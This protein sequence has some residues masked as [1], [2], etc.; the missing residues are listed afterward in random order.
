LLRVAPEIRQPT[1]EIVAMLLPEGSRLG[2]ASKT[3]RAADASKEIAGL[4]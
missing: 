1:E 3:A 2:G 4:K